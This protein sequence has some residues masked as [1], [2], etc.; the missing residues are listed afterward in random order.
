MPANQLII[1]VRLSCCQAI[2]PSHCFIFSGIR[3]LSDTGPQGF[4]GGL[5]SAI[6]RYVGAD[7]ADPTTTNTTSVIPM[8]E[9]NLHVS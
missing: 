9:T 6:L 3:A 7:I 5:N 1:T 2:A 4:D 8:V